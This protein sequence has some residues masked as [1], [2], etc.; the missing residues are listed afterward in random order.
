[1]INKIFKNRYGE[2]RSG[3]VT[4]PVLILI[5]IGL[6]ITQGLA[7]EESA[8]NFLVFKILITILYGL[9][10]IG[11]GILLFKMFYK[12]SLN[13]IGLIK[14]NW[15]LEL[16][17][18]FIIGAI[19]M[20][21]IYMIFIL[22][23]QA[24]IIS[25][26]KERIFSLWIIIEFLSLGVFVFVEE[27]LTRGFLM[28]AL[29]TTRK[30]SIIFVGSSLIFALFHLLNDGA[31]IISTVNTFLAGLLFAYMFIKTGKLWLSTGYHLAWNFFLG[32]VF[33][34]SVS[35]N[36]QTSI[37]VTELGTKIFLVG[38]K[39]GPEG[40]IIVT[41]IL[42]LGFLYVR[43]VIKTPTYPIWSI[44]NNLPLTRKDQN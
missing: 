16:L 13:Q 33:G 36:E 27:F 26:S 34:M 40:G 6:L 7:P 14:K 4:I 42:L 39:Y 30:K 9:I 37:F 29:K 15:L 18:G 22:L 35:G 24:N 41:F 38:G 2:I 32:T 21:M 10:T 17:H 5:I 25:I 31:T 8:K 23:D 43:F 3:W 44:D 1:M 12:R 28:T 19:S 20:G 11:G